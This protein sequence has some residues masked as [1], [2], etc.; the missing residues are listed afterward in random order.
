VTNSVYTFIT[1]T[2]GQTF[3]GAYTTT[4][5]WT[6]FQYVVVDEGTRISEFIV[7][8]LQTNSGT[9]NLVGITHTV[10]AKLPSAPSWRAS[11]ATL[12]S[13]HPPALERTRTFRVY[14]F[15]PCA[16]PTTST[17]N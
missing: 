5:G 8:R 2:N 12:S 15:E 3:T 11:R 17:V 10:R 13:E 1:L 14:G 9:N 16:A 4:N 6:F 7:R